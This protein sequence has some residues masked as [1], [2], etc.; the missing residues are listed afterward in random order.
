M[1]GDGPDGA[2]L[3]RN[4]IDSDSPL[5][6]RPLGALVLTSFDCEWGPR[7]K[8]GSQPSHS[9]ITATFSPRTHLIIKVGFS[10]ASTMRT[11]CNVEEV[12]EGE[13]RPEKLLEVSYINL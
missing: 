12:F 4:W 7:G 9:R 8:S 1:D 13:G 2:A 10:N 11:Y 5:T 6:G 3:A